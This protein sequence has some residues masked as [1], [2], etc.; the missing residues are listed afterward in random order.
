V[1]RLS[2][3]AREMKLYVKEEPHA[4]LFAIGVSLTAQLLAEQDDYRN[5]HDAS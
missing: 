3:R 4:A 2:L 1:R 5:N